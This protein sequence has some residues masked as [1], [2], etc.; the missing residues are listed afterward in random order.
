MPQEHGHKCDVRWLALEGPD[1]RGM[2][3]TGE[4]MIEFS[5]SHFTAEGLFRA[6]HTTDLQPRPE[7]ILDLDHAQRGLGTGSCGPDTL[8]QYRLLEHTYRFAYRLR[9]L[10]E[11]R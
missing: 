9:L 4:P 11:G 7:I 6:R 10:G 5:V 1:G 8:P 3:V 2:R